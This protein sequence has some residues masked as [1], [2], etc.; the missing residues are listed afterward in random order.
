MLHRH[1]GSPPPRHTLVDLFHAFAGLRSECIQYDNGYRSWR[2]TWAELSAAARH[3][4]VRLHGQGLGKGDKVLFWGENRP[5]WIVAFWGCVIAGVIVVPIDYRSSVSL[6]LR[7]QHITG[8]RL[9]LIGEEVRLP[10]QEHPIP[11]WRLSELQWS[12]PPRQPETISLQPDDIAEIVF[13]SGATGEPKGVLLTH[14]NILA[15]VAALETIVARYGKWFQPLAPLRFLGLIPL[16]H[17]FGQMLTIFFLPL[18]PASAVFMRGYSPH[19]IT[20]QIHLRRVSVV[21]A[22]PKLL[23]VLRDHL[24]LRFPEISAHAPSLGAPPI[25]WWRFRRIHLL[26]GWKFWAFAVGAAPLPR[27]LE[28]FWARIGIAIIQGYGLTETSPI[29]A[30][31][32]PFELT[33]GTVGKPIP[34]LELTVAPDGEVLVR[35]ESVTPGYYQSAAETAAAFTGGW[36]HTGDL[37]SL[38]PAGNLTIHGRKKE[39]IVTPEGLNV[40]PEDVEQVLDHLPGVLD[41]AVVGPDRVHAVLVLQ[42]GID[43]DEIVRQANLRLEDHQKIRGVSVWPGPALP[44]TEGTRKLRHAAIQQWVESGR[45]VAPA[46]AQLSPLDLVRKYAP[47]RTLPRRPPSISSA[48]APSI[49]SAC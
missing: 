25:R 1:P 35:G 19:E 18:I 31:N 27:E 3:F 11:V 42:D 6:L 17:M 7:V 41:S 49:V 45:T 48:S 40:V 13:T 9:L 39:L 22:V 33:P 37:G 28:Q 30:F 12:A 26:L 34:G 32:N 10:P 44:R 36:F 4:A 24:L 29:V 16:S 8:A 14:R 47:G 20:R 43:P 38:D 5:E 21:I 2:Y 23:E 15:N 46:A